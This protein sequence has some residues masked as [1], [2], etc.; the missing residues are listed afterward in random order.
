MLPSIQL[1]AV[2]TF[3]SKNGRTFLGSLPIISE[4][5]LTFEELDQFSGF[6]LYECN[7]PT[8][9]RDPSE[10]VLDNLHDRAQVYVDG[11]FVGVLSRENKIY[12]LPLTAGNGEK[13]QILVENQGRINFQIADDYKV[14][15]FF[16]F[17][18]NNIFFIFRE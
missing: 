2:D 6:V 11:K 8:F 5:A 17:F 1:S 16:F 7:L 15:I 3:L 13:L 4:K 12:S 9:T 18:Q 14:F 10:L